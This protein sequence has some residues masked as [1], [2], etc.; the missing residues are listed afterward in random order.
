MFR[1]VTEAAC[2]IEIHNM[3]PWDL[4]TEWLSDSVVGKC[5]LD[6]SVCELQM[7]S[8]LDEGCW[9]SSPFPSALMRLVVA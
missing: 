5:H 7:I 3:L 2:R 4:R 8:M 6:F 1:D 9:A